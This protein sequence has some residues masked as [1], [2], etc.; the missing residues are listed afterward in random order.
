VGSGEALGRVPL[1]EGLVLPGGLFA[2]ADCRTVVAFTT[3]ARAA[4][5]GAGGRTYVARL[6]SGTPLELLPGPAGGPTRPVWSSGGWMF[7]AAGEEV[8]AL[9]PG[10]P[11]TE[12]VAR[13][14]G[15]GGVLAAEAS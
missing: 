15:L 10:A 12:R 5:G 14:G 8:L 1:P 9:R 13:I 4:E 7:L 3:P 2:S 6:G 11:G